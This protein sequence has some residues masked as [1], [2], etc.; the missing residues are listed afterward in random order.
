MTPKLPCNFL[1]PTL[2]RGF[3]R[4]RPPAP[5]AS[6]GRMLVYICVFI[7][8]PGVSSSGSD[9][10]VVSGVVAGRHPRPYVLLNYHIKMPPPTATTS[11]ASF[12]KP[13]GSWLSKLGL[14]RRRLTPRGSPSSSFLQPTVASGASS[15]G[16]R[17]GGFSEVFR[18]FDADGDGKVSGAELLAF[19]KSVGEDVSPED[20][21][22][23][24]R[25]LDSDGDGLM[26]YGDFVRL[27]GRGRGGST[28]DRGQEHVE[29]E[30]DD[31]D[32]QDLRAAFEMF[33]AEKGAGCITPAGLRRAL[34]RLGEKTSQEECSA[35]IRAFD[36]DGNGVLDYQEFYR[37]M[38]TTS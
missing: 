11:F 29:Q 21:E 13:S 36:A 17:A 19:L 18:R 14:P 7:G 8:V 23:V 5:F 25:D 31:E 22:R 38:T 3:S 9:Q 27:M 2:P 37:M 26:D 6:H 12:L 32:D 10:R 34:G 33:V 24:V 1:S 4:K 15:G 16:R 30:E 20:V 28:S 35:M